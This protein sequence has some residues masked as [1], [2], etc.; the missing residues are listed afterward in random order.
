MH[1]PRGLGV[2]PFHLE[3]HIANTNQPTHPPPRTHRYVHDAFR[4]DCP[5]V[6]PGEKVKRRPLDK[7][8]YSSHMCPAVQLGKDCE[9][10]DACPNSHNV[11]EAASPE[12]AGL[13]GMGC[14]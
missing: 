6:H 10:G 4:R 3:T 8:T 12:L 1:I 5:F 14:T 13:P 2:A 7:Y 9:L 11:F